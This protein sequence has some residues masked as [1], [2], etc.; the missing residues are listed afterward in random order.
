M[1]PQLLPHR[2]LLLLTITPLLPPRQPPQQPV[3][4]LELPHPPLRAH[5]RIRALLQRRAR[6]RRDAPQARLPLLVLEAQLEVGLALLLEQAV[7][8]GVQGE[9]G[10]VVLVGVGAELVE[11]EGERG[12]V[13]GNEG[14]EGGGG[15]VERGD[16]GV[17]GLE[18]GAQVVD[19]GGLVARGGEVEVAVDLG[20]GWGGAFLGG[21]GLEVVGLVGVFWRGRAGTYLD[22]LHAVHDVGGLVAVLLQHVAELLY[23][24]P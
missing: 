17:G 22:L 24:L 10:V 2:L 19:L 23:D 8:V 4:R 18:L 3:L 1:Q 21:A 15:R 11:D 16:G 20:E 7:V 13:V 14:A 5:A 9:D 12:F 6:I